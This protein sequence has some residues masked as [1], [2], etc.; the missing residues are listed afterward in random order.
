MRLLRLLLL[1]FPRRTFVFVGDAGYGT[2]EVARFCRR[3]CGRLT[4]VSKPHPDANPFAPPPA[5]RGKGRPR[6]KGDALPKPREAA[7]AARR[8]RRSEVPHEWWTVGKR[9][10]L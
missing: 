1:R 10:K 8:T 2:H 9:C 7:A 6:V 4:L 5:Y 3:H